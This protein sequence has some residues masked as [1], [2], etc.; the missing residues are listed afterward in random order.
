MPTKRGLQVIARKKE[1]K[2]KERTDYYKK[3]ATMRRLKK[4]SNE[5][6]IAK[7]I[8]EAKTSNIKKQQR[9]PET[10]AH[11]IKKV[12]KE[13]PKKMKAKVSRAK[14]TKLRLAKSRR[15]MIG[16]PIGGGRRNPN[17]KK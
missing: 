7:S 12:E 3:K 11:M 15:G 4:L 17:L 9:R 13:V 6:S 5:R 16:Q 2:A 10:K 1:E 8:A 14:R